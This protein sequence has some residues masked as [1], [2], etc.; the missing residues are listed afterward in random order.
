MVARLVR[1]LRRE[2]R[3][4]FM[5]GPSQRSVRAVVSITSAT[6]VGWESMTAWGPTVSARCGPARRAMWPCAPTWMA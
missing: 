3:T 1:M 5:A 2:D 6:A 4:L